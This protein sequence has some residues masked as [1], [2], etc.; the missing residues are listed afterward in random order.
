MVLVLLYTLNYWQ[1]AFYMR[2]GDVE[3]D[4]PLHIDGT[5]ISHI[6][7]SFYQS[8]CARRFP[9]REMPL[10][11]CLTIPRHLVPQ[12]NEDTSCRANVCAYAAIKLNR[13]SLNQF[14][15]DGVVCM[16]LH[17][18][19]FVLK[20]KSFPNTGRPSDKRHRQYNPERHRTRCRP[21]IKWWNVQDPLPD[22]THELN[23]HLG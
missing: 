22:Q 10:G 9:P 23:R 6:V 19:N 15:Q 14:H 3:H 21:S 17:I 5:N 20:S 18:A 11:V 13:I 12:Q 16:R 8:E 1:I 4:C 7:K 2:K